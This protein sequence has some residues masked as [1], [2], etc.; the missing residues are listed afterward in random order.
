M[1]SEHMEQDPAVEHER[2]NQT[3]LPFSNT[4][5]MKNTDQHRTERILNLEFGTY[6]SVV[7]PIHTLTIDTC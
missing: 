7:T 6:L 3:T 5:I 4:A 1:I 2:I